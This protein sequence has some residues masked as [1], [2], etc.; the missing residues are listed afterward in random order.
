M[1]V[2]SR[3]G[4]TNLTL[5]PVQLDRTGF[6]SFCYQVSFCPEKRLFLLFKGS[7]LETKGPL[8]FMGFIIDVLEWFSLVG[9]TYKANR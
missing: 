4:F 5:P 7:V 1:E 6:S 8:F 3:F 2:G 9:F